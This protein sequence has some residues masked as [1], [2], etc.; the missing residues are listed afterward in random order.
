[1][2]LTKSLDFV[3]FFLLSDIDIY[4]ISVTSLNL[5]SSIPKV[6]NI[7]SQKREPESKKVKEWEGNGGKE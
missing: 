3:N 6:F 2:F 1:M 5:F 7:F 4:Y